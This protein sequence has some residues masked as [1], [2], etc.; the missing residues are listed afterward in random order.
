MLTLIDRIMSKIK[1][2]PLDN[3]PEDQ[4][5][6]LNQLFNKEIGEDINDYHK[7]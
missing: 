4:V 7:V 3:I 6:I 1:P 5:E 2:I